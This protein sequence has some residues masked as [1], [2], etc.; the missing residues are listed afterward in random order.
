[1]ILLSQL[2]WGIGSSFIT[3]AEEAWIAAEVGEENVGRVYMRGSQVGQIGALVGAGVSVAL[4]SVRLNLPI[5]LGGVLFMLL[6]VFLIFFMPEHHSQHGTEKSERPTW[7]GMG[8]TFLHGSRMVRTSPLLLTIVA[9]PLFLGLSSEGLDR[10]W[11]A[12]I[13]ANFTLPALGSLNPVTWFA[14]IRAGVMVL[15]IIDS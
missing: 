4:A 5:V 11:T 13:V 2:G 8:E 1:M 6:A 3:G 9:V 10:L 7:K 14:V 12:H 15:G